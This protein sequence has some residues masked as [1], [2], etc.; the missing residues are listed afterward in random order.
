MGRV[1]SRVV[2]SLGEPMLEC[3]IGWTRREVPSGRIIRQKVRWY[4]LGEIWTYTN[5]SH[6]TCCGA[7]CN[8][9]CTFLP[10][11]CESTYIL[12]K[13]GEWEGEGEGEGVQLPHSLKLGCRRNLGL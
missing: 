1:S 12:A 11:L 9:R 2:L 6:S 5:E 8:G 4:H 13:R 3:N 10:Q 7:K